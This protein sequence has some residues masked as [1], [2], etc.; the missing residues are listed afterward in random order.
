KVKIWDM[1]R[2]IATA[3]IIMPSTMVRLSAGRMEM[4]E[5]EQAWCF[6]AGANS[7]FTGEKETLLVTPNPGIPEDLEMLNNLGLKPMVPSSL[8]PVGLPC[9]EISKYYRLL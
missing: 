6:M 9:R 2:M 4:D 3:R 8:A 7:I 5:E 1:V